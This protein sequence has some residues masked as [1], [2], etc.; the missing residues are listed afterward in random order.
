MD[1]QEKMW[2]FCVYLCVRVF[3]LHMSVQRMYAVPIGQKDVIRF[4]RFEGPDSDELSCE[5]WELTLGPLGE[6]PVR[7]TAKTSISPAPESRFF[8]SFPSCIYNSGLSILAC[9]TYR[10]VFC[11]VFFFKVDLTTAFKGCHT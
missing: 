9:C 10:R 5:C 1:R 6:H 8:M 11:F 7:F 3:C 2:A 4:P